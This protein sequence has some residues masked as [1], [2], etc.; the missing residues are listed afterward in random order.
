[1]RHKSIRE[2]GGAPPVP[3]VHLLVFKMIY[4]RK[5]HIFMNIFFLQKVRI[6]DFIG[7]LRFAQSIINSS[8]N[9]VGGGEREWPVRVTTPRYS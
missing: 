6:V 5:F 3:P 8:W 7:Q 9:G 1:M 4:S 2:V